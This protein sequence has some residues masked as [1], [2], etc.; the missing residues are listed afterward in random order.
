M[1]HRIQRLLEYLQDQ[2]RMSLN[3][4]SNL[5]LMLI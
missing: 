2:R 5:V 4:I 3:C 1:L